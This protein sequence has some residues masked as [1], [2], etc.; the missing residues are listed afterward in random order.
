MTRNLPP[1]KPQK[2]NLAANTHYTFDG[3]L[4]G[5]S[6]KPINRDKMLSAEISVVNLT[7]LSPQDVDDAYLVFADK[8]MSVEDFALETYLSTREHIIEHVLNSNPHLRRSF[9]QIIEGMPLVVSPWSEVHPDE[10]FAIKQAN[11]LM[12]EF[13]TLSSEQK[14]WF[15]EHHETTTNALLMSATSGLDI[16][17]QDTNTSMLAELDLNHLL[18]GSGAVIA[19]AQVQGD[20]I[21]KK[22]E[23]LC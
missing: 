12:N 8:R 18:A 22:N 2:Y 17:Q 15:A 21:S 13:L 4:Q 10:E 23:V 9:S 1:E 14:K 7:Q 3:I 19:G 11:D 16:H 6:V 5:T 20:K